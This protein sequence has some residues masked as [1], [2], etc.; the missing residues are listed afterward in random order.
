MNDS[1]VL[2]APGAAPEAVEAARTAKPVGGVLLGQIASLVMIATYAALMLSPNADPRLMVQIGTALLVGL[3]AWAV[4]SWSW[5]SGRMFE[6]Y[7]LF[8]LSMFLF[9]G[10][11][12]VLDLLGVEGGRILGDRYND[13]EITP[14]ILLLLIAFWAFH[15]GA[16]LAL[17]KMP[18]PVHASDVDSAS[19]ARAIGWFLIIIA[20]VP[21]AMVSR[22][23]I[24]L[25]ADASYLA[26]YQRSIGRGLETWQVVLSELLTP[27]A[28]FLLSG[29]QR[30]KKLQWFAAFCIVSVSAVW[31]LIGERSHAVMPLLAGAWLWHSRIRRIP[32]VFTAIAAVVLLGSFPI[33][34]ILRNEPLAEHTSMSAA[35]E[36]I[37]NVDSPF[38]ASIGEMGNSLQPV[39][40]TL[41]LVP[42]TRPHELGLGYLHAVLNIFPNFIPLLH[43][44]LPYG[45]V[46]NWYVEAIDPAYAAQGGTWGF[47]MIAEAYLEFGWLGTPLV[48]AFFGCVI[49]WLSRWGT[50]SRRADA[51]AAVA[52]WWVIVLHFPRGYLESYTRQFVLW[53]L[54]PYLLV[55]IWMHMNPPEEEPTSS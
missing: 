32:P 53:S 42:A 18:F 6:P 39:V 14:A 1:T 27:G 20:I 10:G 22:E 9:H 16:L 3:T 4:I 43:F 34:G 48:L 55:T 13:S 46:E 50:V 25:R 41:Q 44:R 40:D 36:A 24:T 33:L 52:A 19:G 31:V 35:T 28:L 17:L 5:L 12:L 54:V 51:A 23:A 15:S 11:Q 2:N 49:G 26:F 30:N 29:A 47:S 21:F 8:V 7:V 38:A 37:R 45:A